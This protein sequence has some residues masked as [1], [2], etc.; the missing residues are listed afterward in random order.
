MT[1]AWVM[2]GDSFYRSLIR[3]GWERVDNHVDQHGLVVMTRTRRSLDSPVPDMG[4][5]N[6]G[7]PLTAESSSWVEPTPSPS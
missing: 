7:C 4:F 2:L 5:E 6:V 1:T 3:D